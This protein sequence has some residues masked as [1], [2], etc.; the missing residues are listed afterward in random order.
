MPIVPPSI[1]DS[2]SN[3]SVAE[4]S[5]VRLDCVVDGDPKPQITWSK[6][7]ER[8]SATDPHYLMNSSGS[9]EVLSADEN[10]AGTYTCA[11]VNV[12]GL[13]EKRISL[14]VHGQL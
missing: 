7:G 10:D 12:A 9:L 1:A 8:I 5:S 6:N 2:P 4:G 14:L 13:R 11:A 3:Y